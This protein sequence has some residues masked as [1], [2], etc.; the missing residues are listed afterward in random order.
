[1][2]KPRGT[3]MVLLGVGTMLSSMVITGFLLGYALDVW[4]DT[5]PLF[6]FSF[7][8]LGFVGGMLKVYKM[9]SRPD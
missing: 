4:L 3:A 8:V 6:M 9:L 7:G 1:M 5:R 2:K